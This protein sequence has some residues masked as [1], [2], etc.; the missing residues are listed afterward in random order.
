MSEIDGVKL[1]FLPIGGVEG[2]KTRVPVELPEDSKPF[3]EILQNEL[4]DLKFSN[5]AQQRLESRNIALSSD[6][7]Q[8][9]QKA[10]SQAEQK[11]AQD[12]L[13]LL[14][15]LAFIVNVRNKTVITAM[16]QDQMKDNVFTNIDS[17]IIATSTK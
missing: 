2:L 17:A 8:A 13:V 15:D 16:T 12:S 9:I 3:D 14:K 5:H 6:D 1:P 10:V 11:G 7:K 4:D